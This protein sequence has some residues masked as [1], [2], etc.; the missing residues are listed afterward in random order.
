MIFITKKIIY[1]KSSWEELNLYLI[2]EKMITKKILLMMRK[3]S[4]TLLGA[5]ILA[6]SIFYII[7]NPQSFTASILSLQEQTFIAEKWWDI[8]YK[9]NS[10]YVDIFL[11]TWEIPTHIDLTIIFNKDTITIDPAMISGQWIWTFSIPDTNTIIIQSLPSKQTIK[12]ESIIMLPFTW[13]IKDILLSE[14]IAKYENKE[15]KAL[16]IW[17][18][19]TINTH[20]S[21]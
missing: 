7:N 18:L 1:S 4:M 16:S 19:H 2:E 14:A 12:T 17:S 6:S 10:G 13:E 5:A 8:A 15:T 20:T 9:T 3:N 11:W 21:Q